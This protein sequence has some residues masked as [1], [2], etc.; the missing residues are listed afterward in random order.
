[1][2]D[3][4]QDGYEWEKDRIVVDNPRHSTCVAG[5]LG[6]HVAR[7]VDSTRSS[8]IGSFPAK[9]ADP[10]LLTNGL[11]FASLLDL[12]LPQLDSPRSKTRLRL[13]L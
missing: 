9:R 1:M 12:T 10:T 13:G 6:S 3:T 5:D 4:I 8:G 2:N 7:G 11:T